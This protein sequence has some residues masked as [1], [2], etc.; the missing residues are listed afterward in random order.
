LFCKQALTT[1]IT[2]VINACSNNNECPYHAQCLVILEHSPNAIVIDSDASEESTGSNNSRLFL[3]NYFDKCVVAKMTVIERPHDK[4]QVYVAK[5]LGKY[6]H[7]SCPTAD[8]CQL[9]DAIKSRNNSTLEILFIPNACK[10]FDSE[11]V[12]VCN[13]IDVEKE[14]FF[15][16]SNFTSLLEI[17]HDSAKSSSASDHKSKRSS[18]SISIGLQTMYSH[19]QHASR[20]CMLPHSFP[21]VPTVKNHQIVLRKNILEVYSFSSKV[22]SSHFKV[23][24]ETHPFSLTLKEPGSCG[25]VGHIRTGLR[26]DMQKV[27][28]CDDINTS[29]PLIP[30]NIMFESCTVQQAGQLGFHRDTLN[31]PHLDR[32]VAVHIPNNNDSKSCL[33]FLYYSR[34]CVGDYS[35]RIQDIER[36]I[37]SNDDMKICDLTRLCLK[38][39]LEMEGIFNYQGSL[40]ENIESLNDIGQRLEVD[41]SYACPEVTTFTG[42]TCF[43]HGAAF[44]KMGYYSVFL[45]VFLSM[46]YLE[47]ITTIDDAL[48]LCIYFGL[49]CNGTTNIAATWKDIEQNLTFAQEWVS[50]KGDKT[51]IF[52]LL[53]ILEKRRRL[54]S[55]SKD[56]IGCCK[57][58]RFQYAN[59][60][61]N[62][63]EDAELIHRY[64]K[65]FLLKCKTKERTTQRNARGNHSMLFKILSS[66][67][68]IGP[69]SFNQFWHS[70]CL[71]GILPVSYI[72]TIAVAPGSGPA[73]LIQT[74]Y[75][76]CKTAEALYVKLTEVKGKISKLGIHKVTEFFLENQMCE[77]WR[78]GMRNKVVTKLMTDDNKRAGFRSDDF[79]RAMVISTPTKNPDI[80]FQNPFTKQYQHLFRVCDKESL[81][82]R[83]S[84]LANSDS[85]SSTLTCDI[86]YSDEKGILLVKWNGDYVRKGDKTASDW[87]S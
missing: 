6:F 22:L 9:Y 18:K 5:D 56:L 46:H 29:E 44:D 23:N 19:Q 42:L 72:Q 14:Y 40:F 75:P 60:S 37:T 64:V 13:G 84:F 25:N 30:T 78:L 74:F 59:Y 54:K 27:L 62:I 52:R 87:F 63:I 51:R 50:K 47:L 57:L 17:V 41:P 39:L 83:P 2:D 81:V 45:N 76:S 38:S 32:T 21:S 61:A 71:S 82:M 73:K 77:L 68:G 11:N 16:A 80:Y 15:D 70:L 79:H 20:Y 48:S 3:N 86:T 85:R 7:F 12:R 55:K 31:C 24:E 35:N 26:D 36:F 53:I 4:C 49:C 33:S 8:V 66:V 43:K 67:K 69:L 65:D 10:V 34:K 1:F 28:Y 58:P